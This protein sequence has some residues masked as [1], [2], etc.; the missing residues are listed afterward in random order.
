MNIHEAELI[1]L[2]RN[3]ADP[4]QAL[5]T[6]LEIIVSFLPMQPESSQEQVPASLQ[7]SA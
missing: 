6:A 5:A 7:E 2:I 3:N 4:S 1:N